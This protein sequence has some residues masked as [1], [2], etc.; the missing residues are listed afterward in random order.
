MKRTVALLL[1][2]TLMMAMG[3]FAISYADSGTTLSDTMGTVKEILQKGADY[4]KEKIKIFTDMGNHWA[5]ETVGKLVDLGIIAGYTDDTFKPNNNITRAEF[6]KTI[7]TALKLDLVE[8]N[9]FTD[10]SNHWAKNEIHT[11][12]E[13]SI[14][15]KAEYGDKYSPNTNITRIEMAKMV[16]RAMGLEDKAGNRA[17]E[18]TDFGDDRDIKSSDKGYVLLASKNGI[19]NGYPDKTFKPNGQ[20]T[21]AEASTMIINM[22]EVIAEVNPEPFEEVD[23]FIEPE[24]NIYIEDEAYIPLILTMELENRKAYKGR[25]NYTFKFECVNYPKLNK[26]VSYSFSEKKY[27]LIHFDRLR[28]YEDVMNS[29]ALFNLHLRAGYTTLDN[30]DTFTIKPNMNLQFK[31]TVNNGEEK[32]EYFYNA[33]TP[34]ENDH[35]GYIPPRYD[36]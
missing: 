15:D 29:N 20:A 4:F 3:G 8:G 11:V 22:L 5:D 23:E 13:N 27:H 25:E 16:V 9:S 19:I 1:I 12:V 2:L 14:I 36:K 10:T 7:R 28:D 6:S 24:V 35:Y 31:L 30:W 21:R 26:K 34:K 17:G 33:Q 32:R 18:K